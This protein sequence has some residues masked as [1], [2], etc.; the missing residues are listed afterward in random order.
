MFSHHQKPPTQHCSAQRGAGETLLDA[1][2]KIIH[3]AEL[4][5]ENIEKTQA[6]AIKLIQDLKKIEEK[7]KL[8]NSKDFYHDGTRK[9]LND[10]GLFS[11]IR[12][13][14]SA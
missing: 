13:D 5:S 9:E 10:F 6:E 7:Q 2:K 14:K 11:K 12:K 1:A 8:Y 3:Q 4:T